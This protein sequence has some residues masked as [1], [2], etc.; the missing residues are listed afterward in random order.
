ML[1]TPIAVTAGP[2]AG[3]SRPAA[4]E[5]GLRTEPKRPSPQCP[6]VVIASTQRSGSTEFE[7]DLAKPMQSI[8]LG[9]WFNP[10][11]GR[12]AWPKECNYKSGLR[13]WPDHAARIT[14]PV[15][16]L[17]A[18]RE[19]CCRQ[20]VGCSVMLRM[21]SPAMQGAAKNSSILRT[22]SALLAD[23]R[24][25]VIVLERTN[26]TAQFCSLRHAAASGDWTGHAERANNTQRWH[27]PCELTEKEHPDLRRYEHSHRSWYELVRR[28]LAEEASATPRL[29]L[30][31]RDITTHRNR[32]TAAVI[33][34]FTSAI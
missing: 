4:L 25:C 3:C 12:V 32:S 10:W 9:E 29:E 2:M 13:H 23:P 5:N 20:G 21:F 28:V 31:F 1:V 33:R 11:G 34:A 15:Q 19:A 7:S 8:A 26:V 17:L 30:T 6:I 24:A 27:P 14:D 16:S 18:V 22:T